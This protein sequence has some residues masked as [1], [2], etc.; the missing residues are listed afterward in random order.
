[1]QTIH[2]NSDG[3]G[4]LPTIK[5]QVTIDGYTQTGAHPNTKTVGNDAA[6]KV[7]LDGT[8][9]GGSGLQINSASNSVIKGLVINSFGNT[10]IEIIGTTTVGTRIEGNFIGTDAS[11]TLDKGNASAA[12]TPSRT[13]SP[14]LWLGAPPRQPATS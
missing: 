8:N 2:V 4:A 5:E 11:G 7:V 12:W 3:F 9:V 6:L 10:G 14:R 13:T 1:M